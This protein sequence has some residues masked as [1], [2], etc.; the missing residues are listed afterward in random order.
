MTFDPVEIAE[1]GEPGYEAISTD[2]SVNAVDCVYC[3]RWLEEGAKV[4]GEGPE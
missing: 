4:E 3:W 1:E 2:H